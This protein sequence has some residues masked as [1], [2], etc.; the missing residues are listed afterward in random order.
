[1][2]SASLLL[3]VTWVFLPSLKNGFV[4]MDDG[5]F[6]YENT[7]VQSGITWPSIRWAFSSLEQ[8]LWHPLTWLSLMLDYECYGLRAWGYHLT[9]LL[10]H[11]ANTALLFLLWQRMTGARWRSALVALLFGLHP[12]HVESVAWVAERKDVLS[13]FF[14][15]LTMLAYG[16]YAEQCKIRACESPAAASPP[17]ASRRAWLYYILA[18]VL[19]L[20]GLMSKA[21]LVSLPL[22]LLLLDA[23]P[24]GRLRRSSGSPGSKPLR[25]LVLEKTPFLAASAV[26]GLLTLNSQRA[27]GALVG[28]TNY[29]IVE[30][31]QN[32]FLSFVQYLRPT[33]WPSELAVFYP[34]PAALPAWQSLLAAALLVLVSIT[35]LAMSRRRPYLAT[36]WAWYLTTLLP[37]IGLVQVGGQSHADRYTYVPLIGVFVLFTWAGYDVARRWRFGPMAASAVAVA[38]TI[39]CAIATRRQLA[40]W[41]DSEVLFRHAL[42]VTKQNSIAYN[43]LGAAL[44]A[45]KRYEE[46]VGELE[47]G[48]KLAPGRAEARMNLGLALARQGRFEEAIPHFY[49]AM[50]LAPD[51]SGPYSSLGEVLATKGDFEGAVLQYQKA[52]RLSP[53][54][55]AAHHNLGIVL[56][57]KDRTAEA[58]VQ[59]EE[60]LR[61]SRDLPEARRHLGVALGREGRADAAVT[62]LQRAVRLAPTDAEAHC[63]LGDALVAKGRLGEAIAEYRQAV[64]LAPGDA[65]ARHNL[66]VA[67]GLVGNAEEAI[68]QLKEAIRI[69]PDYAEAQCN[70]GIAL[71]KQERWD[72]AA[73]HLSEA[74]KLNSRLPEAYRNLGI[75]LGRQ[76]HLD[77]ATRCFEEGLK[78]NS[79][80]AETHCDL[81]VALAKQ[82]RLDDAVAHFQKALALQ[83]DYADAQ[84]YLQNALQL[85]HSSAGPKP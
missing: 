77:E 50:R 74:V 82:G 31:V 57:M 41:K 7:H 17:V 34:Y 1:M 52:I 18:L 76:G 19:F 10:L 42:A 6:V 39:C 25:S 81:G 62:E 8:G 45:Q 48:L 16:R 46:A 11:A 69:K 72:D 4:N 79:N 32:A 5:V 27:S 36:G 54:D 68:G 60:A 75:A 55:A 15:I 38:I 23:W 80:S 37:V 28:A 64:R 84:N 65:M 44:L 20:C 71:L 26:F 35:L 9:N 67:M 49:E 59:F 29:P 33:C 70:L 12:L 56:G 43:N 22:V 21:M 14:W 63:S 3:L 61:L 53:E 66:G 40:C 83:S 85:K 73:R 47:I 78:L 13:T 30:R 58:I 24:L 2:V 51:S